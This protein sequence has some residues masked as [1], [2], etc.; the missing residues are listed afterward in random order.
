M[1]MDKLPPNIFCNCGKTSADQNEW[2][3]TWWSD[4]ES[5]TSDYTAFDSSQRGDSLGLEHILMR[6]FGLDEAWIDL[7]MQFQ[8]LLT[9]GGNLTDLYVYWKLHIESTVIGPKATG[10]DT[11]E[12]GTYDFNTYFNLAMIS[13]MYNPP[14]GMPLA[15]GGDDMAANKRLK[16]TALWTRLSKRFI[17]EAKVEFTFRPDFCGYYLTQRGCFKNPRLLLLKTLWHIDKGDAK[18]VDI[19]YAADCLSAYSMGDFLHDYC[20]WT[21]LECQG[22]LVEYY[23]KLYPQWASSMFSPVFSHSFPTHSLGLT[24]SSSLI[25]SRVAE[26]LARTLDS[27]RLVRG[28]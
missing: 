18:T 23:H 4:V 5:T 14:S 24:S 6:H 2:A 16:L 21:E 3:K 9:T 19:N 10:R 22:F 11:G 8:G 17:I 12:P 20:T 1:V 13:L 25:T 7:F 26:F 28:V 15:V 27:P